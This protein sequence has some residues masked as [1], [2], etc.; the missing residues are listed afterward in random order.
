MVT[1]WDSLMALAK[2]VGLGPELAV[3]YKRGENVRKIENARTVLSCYCCLTVFVG[4]AVGRVVGLAEGGAL[5]VDE[6]PFE[7]KTVGGGVGGGAKH[8]A[9]PHRHRSGKSDAALAQARLSLNPRLV[10]NHEIRSP[11][12]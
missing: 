8:E 6:G 12:V 7:R 10:C 5:G 9:G 3:K 11:Q 2:V 4:W 1:K